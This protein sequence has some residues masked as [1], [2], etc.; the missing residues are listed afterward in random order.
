[1][2]TN[3]KAFAIEAQA[4]TQRKRNSTKSVQLIG[5]QIF[6]REIFRFPQKERIHSI[7][8]HLIGQTYIKNTLGETTDA[9]FLDTSFNF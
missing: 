4:L 3:D 9:S 6:K 5:E 2:G 8:F 7:Y 1:M